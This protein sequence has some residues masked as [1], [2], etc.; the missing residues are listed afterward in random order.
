VRVSGKKTMSGSPRPSDGG[1][2]EN[3]KSDQEMEVEAMEE[4]E[5][6]D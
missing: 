6:N 2:P 3:R 4:E 1:L 5:I